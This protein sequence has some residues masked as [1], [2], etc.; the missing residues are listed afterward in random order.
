MPVC[1]HHGLFAA[2]LG[3]VLAAGCASERRFGD[4]GGTPVGFEVHVE[5]AFFDSMANHQLHAGGGAGAGFSNLGSTGLEPGLS[6]TTIHL[7]GE[8][9]AGEAGVF[10]KQVSWGDNHFTVPLVPGRSLV[11]SIQAE[12]GWEGWESLGAVVIPSGREP[13]V[14]IVLN[15]NGGKVSATDLAAPPTSRPL[16]L[17]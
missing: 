2:A 5:L 17:P 8:D 12:G 4:P 7:I 3:A 1:Y 10:R 15:A 11:L 13:H 9:G 14:Q 16:A 6:S